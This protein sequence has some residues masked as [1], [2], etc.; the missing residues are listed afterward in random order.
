MTGEI[1]A[2]GRRTE[3]FAEGCVIFAAANATAGDCRDWTHLTLFN[4]IASFTY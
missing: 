3:K 2:A 1:A 4:T